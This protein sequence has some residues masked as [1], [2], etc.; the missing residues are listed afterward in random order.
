ML[1]WGEGVV[2]RV[3]FKPS[4]G[5]AQ[6]HNLLVRETHPEDADVV[7]HQDG[8]CFLTVES[9]IHL[10]LGY[11]ESFLISLPFISLPKILFF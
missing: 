6:T 9:V 5:P 7:V 4:V 8:K 10:V 3:I 1:E 2:F 11:E